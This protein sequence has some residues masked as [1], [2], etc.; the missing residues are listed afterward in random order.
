MPEDI[1]KAPPL[2]PKQQ[3]VDVVAKP[4]EDKSESAPKEQEAEQKK[5][6]PAENKP[7]KPIAAIIMALLIGGGLIAVAILAQLQNN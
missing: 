2:H 6:V 7:K 5:P 4:L 1:Q 3:A